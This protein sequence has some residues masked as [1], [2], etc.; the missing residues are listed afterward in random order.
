MR[1]G[2]RRHDAGFT[3]IEVLASVA[4]AS[5]VMVAIVALIHDVAYNF[6]R[7]TRTASNADRL[8]LAIERLAADFASVGPVPQAGQGAEMA[9][10]FVGEPTQLRFV[11]AGGSA[12]GARSEE[13]VAL[14]VEQMEGTAHLV[15]RRAKWLGPRTVFA[16]V[17]LDDPVRLLEGRIELSFGYGSIGQDGAVTWSESWTGQP[18][19]PRL[20]RL[21]IR[22]QASGADLIPAPEFVLRADAPIACAQ[23]RANAECLGEKT[24]AKGKGAAKKAQ[25]V[26]GKP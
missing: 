4:I 9:V 8:L 3:L 15:R 10:A 17:P 19:L 2:S 18:M 21:T 13:V 12:A 16:D 1:R 25:A 14:T 20:V 22:D 11:T 26:G 7:G 6:D 23:A 5:V 24:E